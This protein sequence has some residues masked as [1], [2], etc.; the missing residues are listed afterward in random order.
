LPLL[1]V[2]MSDSTLDLFIDLFEASTQLALQ[3][4]APVL[5]TLLVTDL[6]LGFIGKT[7]PQLNI[8]TAGLS[9][10]A[11]VGMLVLIFGIRITSQV[12]RD[13]VWDDTQIVRS[14]CIRRRSAA[15][16]PRRTRRT[17][18][19]CPKIVAQETA[20]KPR[21]PVAARRLATPATSR[22]APIFPRR[23]CSSA[24]FFLLKNFGSPIVAALKRII[25]DM[26]AA[27]SLGNFDIAAMAQ[28]P[29]MMANAG[30]A[31]APLFSRHRA[32]RDRRQHV[33]GGP[34]LQRRPPDS[35][36]R[37]AQSGEGLGRIFGGTRSLVRLAMSSSKWFSSPPWPIAPFMAA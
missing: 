20:Q 27:D 37:R 3:L 1:S 13:A 18:E 24:F 14:R 11:L 2:G 31:I 22:A 10:R 36:H 30:A 8:M 25:T 21:H 12:I 6:A 32:D 29:T 15:L 5:V 26:L 16:A 4:A 33:A 28:V 9:I 34:E 23:S 17:G 35:Q 7:M 19:P